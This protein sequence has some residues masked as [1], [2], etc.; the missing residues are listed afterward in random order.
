MDLMCNLCLCRRPD[1]TVENKKMREQIDKIFYFEIFR[2]SNH[3]MICS[4]CKDTVISFYDYAEQVN[5]NQQTLRSVQLPSTSGVE[6]KPQIT[7]GTLIKLECSLMDEDQEEY[8]T[9]WVD[10]MDKLET[11]INQDSS[12][13]EEDSKSR[14]KQS[15]SDSS[16]D[17][18]QYQDEITGDADWEAA[19]VEDNRTS[20]KS[21]K[22]KRKYIRRKIAPGKS[23]VRKKN[24][25][26]GGQE[27]YSEDSV[28]QHFS[29]VCDMCSKPLEDFNE[30]REH[31]KE[32]HG[33]Q[34]YIRCCDKKI[35]KKCWMVEHLQV[36]LNPDTFHC[37]T[38]NKSYSS[39]RVLNDHNKEVHASDEQR[40]LSCEGCTKR[41]ASKR[42]LN[43]HMSMA[44]GSFPCPQCSRILASQGS[45]KHHVL[46]IHGEGEQ[47][48]CD[49]CARVYR[50]KRCLETH[51]KGHLGTRQEDKVQCTVCAV[52]FTN[53]YQL[54]K[55]MNRIHIM[56]EQ[57]LECTLCGKQLRNREAL[58]GHMHRV[59]SENR[60]ECEFCSKT[61][62]RPHHMREHV[63]IH[64]TG[65]DLYNC[66]YCEERFNSKN[67]QYTH[68]K[69]VHPLEFEEELRRRI[70]KE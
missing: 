52:W 61:F 13:E 46:T 64:H 66:N 19:A 44:H 32:A 24:S 8:E 29:L 10:V 47:F 11:S 67:K 18:E 65:E 17:G 4:S 59:H 70:M 26:Q 69:T 35:F 56:P 33:Q 49:I 14:I 3:T 42:H 60:F 45:L 31:F 25:A 62:K 41:F 38:C 53:K 6:T 16:S 48:I 1:M 51:V 2:Q 37:D 20:P 54:T 7:D 36:H 63:A 57:M 39:K 43:A 27:S 9:E 15:A 30:L 28:L 22:L 21:V 12:I 34:G 50:T 5:R 58:N 55:H 40:A 68:R 23:S